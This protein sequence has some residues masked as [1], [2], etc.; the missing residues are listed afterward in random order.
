MYYGSTEASR[1]AFIHY[2][3]NLH[4]LDFTGKH[5][6]NVELKIDEPDENGVGEICMRGP[7]VMPGYWNNPEATKKAIDEDKWIH[8]GDFGIMDEDGYVKVIGRMNDEISVDGMK[9][10]PVEVETII[11]KLDFVKEATVCAIPDS[12]KYQVVG[13]AV[14]LKEDAPTNFVELIQ[15]H[16]TGLLEPFKVPVIVQQ[17]DKI[18]ANELGKIN[19]KELIKMLTPETESHG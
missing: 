11:L 18:P 17:M 16:C 9:C 13:A 12:E 4:R 19:R 15:E 8:S 10:Q 5:T 14:V 6:L 1:C 7:N 3:T 2:N